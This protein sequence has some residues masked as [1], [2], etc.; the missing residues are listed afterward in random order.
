MLLYKSGSKIFL[1]SKDGHYYLLKDIN[2]DDMLNRKN[3]HGHLSSLLAQIVQAGEESH[4]WPSGELTWDA[5]IGGQ[6]VWASGVTYYNSRNARLEEATIGGGGDFYHKIYHAKRPH[7]F[8]KGTGRRVRGPGADLS[9][10]RDSQ[11]MVPEPEL[12]LFINSDGDWVGCTIGNDLSCR[13]LEG[14]NPLYLT[15]AKVWD[16]SCGLGP[17]ILV[18]P[19]FDLKQKAVEMVIRRKG[20]VA[21]KGSVALSQMVRKPMELVEALFTHQSFPQGVF[22]LTGTGIV[23]PSEFSLQGGDEVGIRIDGIGELNNKVEWGEDA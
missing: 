22:L 17:G 15:Q 13:D 3:L 19:H 23:P 10:R 5:P 14:E 4:T 18:T 1:G 21:F 7:L 6:E 16:G 8:F 12:C 20:Q 9:L 11:W 2:W